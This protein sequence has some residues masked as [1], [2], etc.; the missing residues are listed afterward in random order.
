[1]KIEIRGARL[2]EPAANRE[3]NASLFIAEGHVA[4]WGQAP[5]GFKADEVVDAHGL[6]ACPGLVDLSA[7]LREPGFEY[8]AT[9]ESEMRAAVAGGVT[10]LACP[11]DTDPPLDEPGLVEM[12]KRRA[13][14]LHQARVLPLGT[15]TVGLKGER[16]AEM[17]EL[18]EAGCVGFFQANAPLA[19]LSVLLQAMRYAATFGFTV[20]LRPQDAALARGG[21][22]HDGEVATRLGL[23][24]IPAIAETVAIRSIVELMAATGARVHL[25]RLSC[26]ASV[27]LVAEAKAKG[28]PLTCDVGVHHLH[29]CDRDIGEFD[30]QANFI[31]PLRDP[32]DRDA[33]RRALAEGVIDAVCSDHTPVDED[34]KLVPFAEA[35]PGATGLELLLPL[36]LRWAS[37]SRIGL[38]AALGAATFRPAK[39]LGTRAGTLEPGA[40]ADICLFDPKTPWVVS[41]LALA[42]QGKNTPFMGFELTGRVARTLVG[43]RTVYT[44]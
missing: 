23:A 19:D 36:V 22:A 17:A 4:A 34:E 1:M 2:V 33:L 37:E 11:P 15:L 32:G 35:A 12:L 26:A 25:A 8:K 21:V 44:A 28:L 13:A 24:P 18:T 30:A 41:P 14:S 42:S 3:A 29:L 10:S 27:A 9:L 20:W 7:R 39:I 43:G 5:D 6:V 38:A 40:V 31:P 16:L